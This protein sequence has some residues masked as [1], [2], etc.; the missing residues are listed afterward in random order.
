MLSQVFFHRLSA[1]LL[2]FRARSMECNTTSR[3]G[4]WVWKAMNLNLSMYFLRESS[5]T[6][7]RLAKVVEV[8]EV[9]Q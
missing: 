8:A 5:S 3:L 9:M 7:G 4:V 6:C 1:N 2:G